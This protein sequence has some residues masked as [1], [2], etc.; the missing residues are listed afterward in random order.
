MRQPK[1]SS[2]ISRK[3]FADIT[4]G[5]TRRVVERTAGDEENEEEQEEEE[6]E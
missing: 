5:S 2:I 1:N 4:K 3:A 6:E